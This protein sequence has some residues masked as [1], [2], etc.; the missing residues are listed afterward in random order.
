MLAHAVF[1]AVENDVELV[2]V[3]N[4]GLSTRISGDGQISD[5]T[6]LFEI[7][8]R[9][10]RVR[11]VDQVRGPTIYSRFGDVFAWI[12]VLITITMMALALVR[13]RREKEERLRD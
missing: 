11:A 13:W 6:A 2:R 5:P 1:R 8:Q 9:S 3:T 4:S 7:T 12:C 10:W